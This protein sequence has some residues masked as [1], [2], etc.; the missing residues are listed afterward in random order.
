M[1]AKGI[2]SHVGKV[3]VSCHWWDGNILAA[4]AFPPLPVPLLELG[5]CIECLPPLVIRPRILCA[6]FRRSDD[7]VGQT[8]VPLMQGQF[9]SP[10][11][12]GP[13]ALPR[14]VMRFGRGGEQIPPRL[15]SPPFPTRTPS[16]M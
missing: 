2:L 11:Q 16:W 6:P 13:S 8:V 15:I 10:I 4:L 14:T 9:I 3:A 1:G 12:K 5:C 7:D